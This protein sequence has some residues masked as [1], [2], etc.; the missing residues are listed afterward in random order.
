MYVV[1]GLI[2]AV[3]LRYSFDGVHKHKSV[4][5]TFTTTAGIV[6]NYKFSP[7]QGG[8]LAPIQ[9]PQNYK[10]NNCS[11]SLVCTR[12]LIF[13]TFYIS[14]LTTFPLKE[15]KRFKNSLLSHLRHCR[16]LR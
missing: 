2:T 16:L 11:F 7:Y 4:S 1:H 5:V 3:K 6:S 10:K 8:F 9:F 13:F 15:E 14:S 12:V